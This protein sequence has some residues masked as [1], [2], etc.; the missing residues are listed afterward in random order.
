MTAEVLLW[1][2]AVGA[3]VALRLYTDRKGDDD[4]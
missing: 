3:L 1:I 2:V 4:E